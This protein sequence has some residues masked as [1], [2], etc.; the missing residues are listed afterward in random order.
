MSTNDSSKNRFSLWH[1]VGYVTWF[2]VLIACFVVPGR[3][4]DHGPYQ[5]SEEEMKRLQAAVEKEAEQ[6]AAEQKAADQKQPTAANHNQ[7]P[8]TKR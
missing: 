5:L 3:L 7:P 6:K 8:G 4:I 2:L 1:V